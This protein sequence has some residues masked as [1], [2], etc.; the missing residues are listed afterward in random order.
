M[1]SSLLTLELELSIYKY[2][3]HCFIKLY[4]LYRHVVINIINFI[5]TLS[6]VHVYEDITNNC[7]F[8]QLLYR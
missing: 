2:W 7:K 3:V 1:E 8:S 4:H 6:S 5:D